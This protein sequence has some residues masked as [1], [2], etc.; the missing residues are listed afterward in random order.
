MCKFISSTMKGTD[1]VFLLVA[2]MMES[3]VSVPKDKNKGKPN[4]TDML[5]KIREKLEQE[6]QN[7]LR[8]LDMFGVDPE[9][10]AGELD[11]PMAS[12]VRASFCTELLDY[13]GGLEKT[14]NEAVMLAD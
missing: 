4:Y 8:K 5:K 6:R 2:K 12:A 1:N 11:T 9:K 7:E 10:F 13:L 14:Q 3:I